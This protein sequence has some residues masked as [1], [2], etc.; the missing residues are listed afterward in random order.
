MKKNLRS[1]VFKDKETADEVYKNLDQEKVK[2]V[3]KLYNEYAGKDES[4][5]KQKLFEMT[6]QGK[7]DGSLTDDAIDQMAKKI[8][9]MLDGEKRSK[10]NSI[11]SMLKNN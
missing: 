2:D 11:V 4:E 8:A 5:L 7:E 6:R 1:N 9:P 3:K 10:L